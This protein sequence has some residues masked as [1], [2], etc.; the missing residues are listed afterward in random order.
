MGVG[1]PR[2]KLKNT[3]NYSR[4]II[5]KAIR[6]IISGTNAANRCHQRT[7][8]VRVLASLL[9]IFDKISLPDRSP[10]IKVGKCEV[11]D[12]HEKI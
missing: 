5:D 12:P 11:Q 10:I 7:S 9:T 2:L 8:L 6:L 4:N 1:N 3:L